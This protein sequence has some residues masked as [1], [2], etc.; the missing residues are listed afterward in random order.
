[1]VYFHFGSI[2]NAPPLSIPCNRLIQF[3]VLSAFA[4]LACYTNWKG[5]MYWFICKSCASCY[6]I[7]MTSV[8]FGSGFGSSHLSKTRTTGSP[9]YRFNGLRRAVT[10]FNNNNISRAFEPCRRKLGY[11]SGDFS[12]NLGD[13]ERLVCQ[14]FS[15]NGNFDPLL[16][17]FENYLKKVC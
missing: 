5:P 14:V 8:G 10:S 17:T 6:V 7:H 4:T 15:P 13:F 1:M 12:V 11:N 16:T 2:N 9:K 3:F